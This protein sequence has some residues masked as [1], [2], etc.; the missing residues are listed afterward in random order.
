MITSFVFKEIVEMSRVANDTAWKRR[1]LK[2]EAIL[3][4]HN[5][6][7]ARE[8]L[9]S[10]SPQQLSKSRAE[11]HSKSQTMRQRIPPTSHSQNS[12]EKVPEN[13]KVSP[14]KDELLLNK[15]SK[16]FGPSQPDDRDHE[17]DDTQ[18]TR[19]YSSGTSIQ[20]YPTTRYFHKAFNPGLPLFECSVCAEHQCFREIPTGLHPQ[21]Y[22][23]SRNWKEFL[24]RKDKR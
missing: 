9:R 19:S 24:R 14:E 16:K 21:L 10:T 18:S 7:M 3:E 22:Q 15:V 6:S 4:R 23:K 2:E 5:V 1:V 17:L 12:R 8:L 11:P 20:S 13:L